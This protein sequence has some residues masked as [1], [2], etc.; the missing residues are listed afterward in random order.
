MKINNIW[1]VSLAGLVVISGNSCDKDKTRGNI[2]H[3]N[4]IIIYADDLGYGDLSCYGATKLHTPNIDRIAKEGIRFT[5]GY[6]T[7]GVCTPSRFGLL[8]GVYPWRH[9]AS[10]L[11]GDAPL[12][13]DTAMYTMPKMLSQAGYKT[14][15]IG[16]W[17]LG[18][19]DGRTNW[20]SKLD[21]GANETGFDYSYLMAATNDRVP[22]VFV[23]DGSVV[24][25]NSDDP[26]SVSY[27]E[28]F[29]GEPTGKDN[30]ELLKMQP[31]FGHDNSIVNGISRIGYM[32][33]GKSALWVDEN[34]AETFLSKTI[35]WIRLQKDR[36][37]F[38]YYALHQPHVPRVPNERFAGLSG[39]GPRG[40]AILEADWC[41]GQLLDELDK[42]GLT[43]NTLVIF[44]SDNGP[45]LNDG[46]A[47]QAKELI[48]NHTPA[49]HLRGGKGSLF[50][51]GTRVP[52]LVRWPA[53]I[54]PAVSDAVVF[55]LDLIA[56]FAKMLDQ[57]LGEGKDS[58]NHLDAFCG[59]NDKGRI[60]L[61]LEGVQNLAI[62]SG[63]WVMIPPSPGPAVQMTTGTE[64]GRSD[65]Y[66][67][68][69]LL[70]DPGQRIN[71]AEKN[72]QRIDE[73]NV[74]LQR[75]INRY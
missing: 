66:Q 68:Y 49:G 9:K 73:M 75:I 60:S 16:K 36:P 21:P 31:S 43:E 26:I 65:V 13:I 19:G 1:L 3:P 11:P 38:L 52:F 59:Q 58:E 56:S 5:N 45:V 47:D 39:M 63:N 71:L 30:P 55:Q 61:V 44:S 15:A 14:A 57:P 62:R 41:V 74:E 12:I 48:G 50:E 64:M 67:L 28:N 54:K 34:M 70:E 6:A 25:L 51:A 46:Y 35:A 29:P 8:T 18:M 17:H 20:N 53:K 7:S 69:N 2:I 10:I 23:E 24:G 4:I 32:K 40:D 27:T 42:L 37:F 33:G 22:C 72:P